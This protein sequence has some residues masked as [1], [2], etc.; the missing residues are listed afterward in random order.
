MA[1]GAETTSTKTEKGSIAPEARS[2]KQEEAPKESA[3]IEVPEA[4]KQTR[5]PDA[6]QK[7]LEAEKQKSPQPSRLAQELRSYQAKRKRHSMDIYVQITVWTQGKRAESRLY[8][9][10]VVVP[11]ALIPTMHGQ[12]NWISNNSP[13]P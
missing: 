13:N 11:V 10:V 3:K 2:L 8:L 12:K 1:R 9:I 6:I 7:K 4:P 5:V